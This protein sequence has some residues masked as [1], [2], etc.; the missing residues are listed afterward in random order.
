MLTLSSPPRQKL[1]CFIYF[2]PAVWPIATSF[3]EGG[4][5][6]SRGGGGRSGKGKPGFLNKNC[7]RYLKEVP[8]EDRLYWSPCN[9]FLFFEQRVH[10]F[11]LLFSEF[12]CFVE[13]SYPGLRITKGH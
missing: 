3:L 7:Q 8:H 4:G 1:P 9:F 10:A 11:N 5:G 2:F 12:C 6:R 13:L